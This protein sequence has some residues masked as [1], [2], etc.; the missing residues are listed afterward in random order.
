MGLLLF[1]LCIV[2]YVVFILEMFVQVP[3]RPETF[4]TEFDMSSNARSKKSDHKRVNKMVTLFNKQCLM[5]FNS[6]S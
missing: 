2:H 5:A 6:V 1:S 3:V 4:S